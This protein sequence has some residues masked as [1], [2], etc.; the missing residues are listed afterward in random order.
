M[1]KSVYV[2]YPINFGNVQLQ[3]N[4]KFQ[5]TKILN[6]LKFEVLRNEN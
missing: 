2:S 5:K 3:N 4:K 1:P 6:I